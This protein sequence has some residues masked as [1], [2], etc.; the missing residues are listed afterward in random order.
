MYGLSSWL[1]KKFLY[2]HT[3][4]HT[5]TH[6]HTR[7]C[8]CARAHTHAHAHAHA[9][10]LSRALSLSLS[11]SLS[12]QSD[13]RPR[14]RKGRHD[15]RNKNFPVHLRKSP[16][17]ARFTTYYNNRMNL[18][19][20]SVTFENVYRSN[21]IHGITWHNEMLDF[22]ALEVTENIKYVQLLWVTKD[23]QAWICICVYI[24]MYLCMYMYVYM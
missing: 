14:H 11:F 1:L 19:E 13:W 5:R 4:A 18:W 22:K 21:K 17:A 23:L 6:I 3:H 9:H 16:L 24:H 8:K 7:I 12:L 2:V 20:F 10:T 15:D